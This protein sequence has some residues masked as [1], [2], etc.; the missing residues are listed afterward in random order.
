MAEEN[1]NEPQVYIS[2]DEA[3]AELQMSRTNLYYYLGQM[4]IES[5]KFSLD[6]KSYIRRTDVERIKVARGAAS[7][8]MR[9]ATDDVLVF[10]AGLGLAIT[11]HSD[12]SYGW[13]FAWFGGAW[14]GPYPSP[15]DAIRTAFEQADRKAQSLRDMPF[16]THAGELFWWDGESWFGARHKDGKLEIQTFDECQNDGYESVQSVI[17]QRDAWLQPATPTGNEQQDEERERARLAALWLCAGLRELQYKV[18]PI[19]WQHDGLLAQ[20]TVN[21]SPIGDLLTVYNHFREEDSFLKWL[22]EKLSNVINYVGPN[23]QQ[24][25]GA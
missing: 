23:R 17:E 24:Q 1:M 20:I 14:E 8:G 15:V 12:P 9:I 3:S 18:D 25:E 2:I 5:K 13:G 16:P 22:R 4:E 21:D 11:P 10:L 6:R 7:T 19:D